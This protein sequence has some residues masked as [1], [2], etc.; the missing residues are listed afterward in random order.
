MEH[1][2]SD[3]ATP[4][5]SP[6]RHAGAVRPATAGEERALLLGGTV[7]LLG[8][9]TDGWAHT[10]S[11]GDLESFLTPWHGVVGLGLLISG[12]VVLRTIGIRRSP[13]SRALDSIPQGWGLALAGVLGF[14]AGFVGDGVW[15]TIFGIESDI[16]ALLSPT[17]LLMAASML[18][19]FTTPLRARSGLDG[20]V[21]T[22]VTFSTLGVA[23]FSLW[24]WSLTWG[25]SGTG[26][27]TTRPT[28][29]LAQA[30]GLAGPLLVTAILLGGATVLL[31]RG[32][33]APGAL[34][35]VVLL[36]PVAI[37]GV[38]EF[39]TV[40][41]LLPFVLGAVAL[42]LA[43]HRFGDVLPSWGPGVVWALVTWPAYWLL[44][45]DA[46]GAGWEVELYPGSVLLCIALA[47]AIG[48]RS[49]PS[50]PPTH[51]TTA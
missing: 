10:A 38:N 13:G 42:E 44:A 43:V 37:N 22:S 2:V 28:A 16:D 45:V 36:A 48:Y 5:R 29:Q 9:F 41:L 26:V 40:Q 24:G 51:T 23:F 35:A 31:R 46:W 4:T 17:H 27:P 39:E 32:R 21:T 34:T 33:P 11:E 14:S 8:L 3:L 30:A 1:P 47:G 20:R 25:L 50:N 7:L 15:H 49:E 18:A 19:V 12:V 6:Q